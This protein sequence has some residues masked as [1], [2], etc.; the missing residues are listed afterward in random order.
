MPPE[1]SI[2]I[3]VYNVEQYLRECLDSVINQTMR[4][5]QIICVDD[6]S[7]DGSPAILEE[8][9]ARDPRIEII[10]QQNRGGGSARNAAYPRIRGKY[11]FFVDPDDWID[12]DLCRLCADKTEATGADFVVLRFIEYNPDP[13]CSPAFDPSLPEIRRTPEEKDEIFP[14]TGTWSKFWQSG[15]LLSNNI[16]FSEGKRPANDMLPA[17]KGTVLAKRIAVLDQP[18]YHYRIRRGSYLQT[19]NEKHFIIIETFHEIEKML[20][21]TGLYESYKN[22]FIQW[23]LIWFYRYHYCRYPRLLRPRFIQLLRRNLTKA[24]RE[25]CRNA[26]PEIFDKDIRNFYLLLVDGGRFGPLKYHFINDCIT[27]K[28]VFFELVKWPERL[29]RRHIIKPLKSFLMA[30]IQSPDLR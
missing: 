4:D 21:E 11:T 24:D 25:F 3:P 9:A 8:Y 14:L 28:D 12:L 22:I 23:K 15:F 13:R 18:L 5:I 29:L 6:G 10:R 27:G 19:I 17:W 16:R 7:T 20:H 26:S 2:V 30:V 1:I